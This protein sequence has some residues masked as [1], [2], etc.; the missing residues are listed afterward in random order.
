[1]EKVPK[2]SHAEAHVLNHP[3]LSKEKLFIPRD[4]EG[5]PNEDIFPILRDFGERLAHHPDFIGVI[6]EGSQ[7]RG[8]NEKDSDLDIRIIY[9]D[10]IQREVSTSL[11][12]EATSVAKGLQND[13]GQKIQLFYQPIE[14]KRHLGEKNMPMDFYLGETLG[15]LCELGVGPKLDLY[16]EKFA[17]QIQRLPASDQE[18]LIERAVTWLLESEDVRKRRMQRRMP[19]IYAESEFKQTQEQRKGMW[20]RRVRKIFKI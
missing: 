5:E 6:I 3:R 12:E 19:G 18:R 2:V 13:F 15:I 4:I 9:D 20:E 14:P 10:D 7:I 16:R 11:V 8:Y 17:K 1:M